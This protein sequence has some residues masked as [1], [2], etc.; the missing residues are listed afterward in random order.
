MYLVLEAQLEKLLK[1]IG[2]YEDFNLWKVARGVVE[3]KLQTVSTY[4]PHSSKHDKTHS[5]QIAIQIANLLGARRVEK[6]SAS[7]IM[8]MLLAFYH[9]DIGM[10]LE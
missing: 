10:V 1:E 5:E 3:K 7:D 2:K 9:H 4:F 8:M 6:L